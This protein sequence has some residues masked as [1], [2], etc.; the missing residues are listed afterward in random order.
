MIGLICGLVLAGCASAPP[1]APAA[2][3]ADPAPQTQNK[4]GGDN[5]HRTFQL[6]KLDKATIKLGGHTF[7]VWIMDSPPK[8]QEGMMYLTRADVKSNEGMIFPQP[9][10][11]QGVTFWMENTYL[12][13]DI[14]FI[15]PEK[16]ILNIGEGKPLD[17]TQIPAKG[18]VMYVVELLGGTCKKM[19][20]KPGA[21]LEVPSSVK[22]TGF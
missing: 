16:K 1:K 12:P 7:K 15:S 21:K 10:P 9:E 2:P 3:P 17:E 19:G 14:I 20:I 22:A 13:L 8:Q 11:E 5:A 18:S 4:T 6:R